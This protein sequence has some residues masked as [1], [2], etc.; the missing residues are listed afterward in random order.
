M[1]RWLSPREVTEVS[2]RQCGTTKPS[3][4]ALKVHCNRSGRAGL[5]AG[6]QGRYATQGFSPG[7]GQKRVP[8]CGTKS[9]AQRFSAGKEC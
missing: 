3:A 8:Q 4:E 5:Q 6:V 9:L 1:Q 2:P 7:R